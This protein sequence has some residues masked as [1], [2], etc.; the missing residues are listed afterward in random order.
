[1]NDICF[2]G[3]TT[4]LTVYEVTGP[5]MLK[6]IDQAYGGHN[7]GNTV[8][9]EIFK[10]LTILFSGPVI[11]RIRDNCPSE[12]LDFLTSFEH[13]LTSFYVHKEPMVTIRIPV[14]WKDMFEQCTGETLEEALLNSSYKRKVY[15]KR[16]KLRISNDIFR[17][18]IDFSTNYVL[19]LFEELFRKPA[20]TN[21]TTLLAVGGDFES[22][23]LINA[24]TQTFP[25]LTV[26]VPEDPDLAVL[27]GAVLYG[28]A[29][30]KFTKMVCMCIL[31]T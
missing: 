26:I 1:M 8:N 19:G 22:S 23:I 18:F 13:K 28:F 16:D 3:A 11:K 2:I 14:V 20:T 7:G 25:N 21:V 4:D 24:I 27:N 29:P 30:Y 31:F 10:F 9:A 15:I 12:Y 17:Q 6:K 5:K